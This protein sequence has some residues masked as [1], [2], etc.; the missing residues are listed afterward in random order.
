MEEQYWLD[1]RVLLII[2][3]SEQHFDFRTAALQVIVGKPESALA[4]VLEVN[5]T[6]VD[7]LHGKPLFVVVVAV[8][9][10]VAPTVFGNVDGAERTVGDGVDS[11]LVETVERPSVSTIRASIQDV[12]VGAIFGTARNVGRAR[13]QR[14]R[15]SRR[16]RRLDCCGR[17]R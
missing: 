11:A 16:W 17:C 13:E 7:F 2:T 9:V 1:G 5:F 12:V 8:V 6:P 10:A 3:E 14:F 4:W 15:S